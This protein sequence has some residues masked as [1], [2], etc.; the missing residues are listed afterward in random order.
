MA[1]TRHMAGIS[2]RLIGA[3]STALAASILALAGACSK[4]PAW[5]AD[6]LEN[7]KHYF[8]SLEANRKAAEL[9]RK[10]DPDVP[11]FGIEE[12]NKYQRV[13]LSEAKL[14]QDAVLDKAHPGLKEHFRAEYEK[15][16]QSILGSYE[17]GA[18]AATGPPSG[19]QIDMQVAG[20]ALLKRW[21]GWFSA[22]SQEIS[23][24]AQAA[25]KAN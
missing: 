5:S 17:A 4:A 14:V 6:E 10:S 24:P 22:H 2:D 20:V 21:N 11:Q 16:L 7:S 15:G 25:A 13:A 18:S 12:I 23:V 3:L 1:T 8:R 19:G 9:S